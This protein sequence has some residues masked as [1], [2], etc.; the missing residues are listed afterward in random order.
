M[1]RDEGIYLLL[2]KLLD[3]QGEIIKK[4]FTEEKG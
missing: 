2:L 4:V 3:G 1:I